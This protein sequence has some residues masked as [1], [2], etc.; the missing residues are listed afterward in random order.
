VE[1][2]TFCQ[3]QQRNESTVSSY[4][5][6][7]KN[8]QEL[9]RIAQAGKSTRNFGQGNQA[10][11]LRGNK[12][13]R[14]ENGEQWDKIRGN[15]DKAELGYGRRAKMLHGRAPG[16]LDPYRAWET[17]LGHVRTIDKTGRADRRLCL[18]M[19]QLLAD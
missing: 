4:P 5:R 16:L 2:V 6:I 3:D 18:M 14:T 10:A 7:A 1:A 8:C 17:V 11:I 9:P 12:E 19:N 15:A 13:E